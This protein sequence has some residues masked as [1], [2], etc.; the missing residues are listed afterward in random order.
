ME[1]ACA[2]GRPAFG[3]MSPPVVAY[4][5]DSLTLTIG[6]RTS[7][8]FA[9]CPSNPP[10]PATVILPEPVGERVLLDGGRHPPAPPTPDY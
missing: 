6:V 4:V 9:A 7:P 2:S 1:Q 5:P 10:T 3:R 8:G